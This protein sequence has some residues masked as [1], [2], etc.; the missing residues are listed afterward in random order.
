MDAP[1][2]QPP[3]ILFVKSRRVT[4]MVC[5]VTGI[6]GCVFIVMKSMFTQMSKILSLLG[7]LIGGF[8][9]KSKEGTG[10]SREQTDDI[11]RQARLHPSGLTSQRTLHCID[12]LWAALWVGPPWA[13]CSDCPLWYS[14]NNNWLS[15]HRLFEQETNHHCDM[16]TWGHCK[17]I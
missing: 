16:T 4:L 3:K 11:S 6:L 15:L 8:P 13:K 1:N 14:D 2:I 7:L 12:L 9:L 10:V 17:Y 5:H